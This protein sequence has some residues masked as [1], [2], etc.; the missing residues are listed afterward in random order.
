MERLILGLSQRDFDEYETFEQL[1]KSFGTERCE[2]IHTMMHH[3]IKANLSE[4]R[5]RTGVRVGTVCEVFKKNVFMLFVHVCD[6]TDPLRRIRDTQPSIFRWMPDTCLESIAMLKTQ[7]YFLQKELHVL[8]CWL[9]CVAQPEESIFL[10]RQHHTTS[11]SS[12]VSK[13]IDY[14]QHYRSASSRATSTVIFYD[15]IDNTAESGKQ[16]LS[17]MLSNEITPHRDVFIVLGIKAP[18][19]ACT[20]TELAPSHEDNIEMDAY[21]FADPAYLPVTCVVLRFRML[22]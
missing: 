20:L 21:S 12:V 16:Y 7:E 18:Y 22:S 14:F 8:K 10:Q 6:T 5:E 2:S 4:A 3:V 19:R 9:E 13:L 17:M 1:H 15:A 11:T